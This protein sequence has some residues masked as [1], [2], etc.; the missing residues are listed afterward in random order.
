[1]T[2]PYEFI[3][4]SIAGFRL[5]FAPRP[6]DSREI[7]IAGLG[8]I[9]LMP[10]CLIERPYGT[11]DYLFMLF[12]DP[13]GM[14]ERP[15]DLS[16]QK[17][18]TMM[19]WSPGKGQYYGNRFQRYCHTWIHCEGTRI[20]RM[21]KGAALPV[22]R[23]FQIPDSSRFQQCLLD[24]H[25]ELVS[26]ARPDSV[27]VINILENCL[28]EIGRSISP[29]GSNVRIPE[30]LLAVRRLIGSAPA[31]NISLDD[32]AKSAGMSVSHFCAQFKKTF[33]L[34]PI[35]CLIQHRMHHA[36]HLLSNR[37][38]TISEIALQTG[39]EDLFHFSKMFKKH[40]GCSPRAMRNRQGVNRY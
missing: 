2:Q 35:E 18:D 34:S 20:S 5:F 7:S 31:Q 29:R 6:L 26:Y 19:I 27:I 11:G 39:Y 12:H 33:G 14:A 22:L 23:P 8:V 28:R 17:P 1:M 3:G 24:L 16:L 15:V 4:R 13:A 9:E 10:P 40:F 38:L 30:N 21:L 25:G 32:L 37:N 36:A